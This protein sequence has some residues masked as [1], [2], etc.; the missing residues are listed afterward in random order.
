MTTQYYIE[1]IKGLFPDIGEQKILGDLDA[2]QKLF[3][4]ETGLLTAQ[5]ELS[6][7]S[8]N[9][10]YSLP[11]GFR[12]LLEVKMYDSNGEPIYFGSSDANITY[13]IQLDKFFIKSLDSTPISAFPSGINKAYL[14]YETLPTT[15]VSRSTALEIE[16]EFRDALK[17]YVLKNYFS[18][19]PVDT[20]AQGQVIKTRD[21]NAVRYHQGEYEKLRIKAKKYKNSKET[22]L[23]DTWNYQDAGR[24]RLPLRNNDTSY[25]STT[26]THVSALGE[27]YEKFA[28]FNVNTSDSGTLTPVLKVGYATMTATKTGSTIALASTADFGVDTYIVS[29]NADVTYVYNSSSSITITLPSFTDLSIQIFEYT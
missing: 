8:S 3:A 16:E 19:Y 13:E 11:T 28:L 26:I 23:G 25:S 6:S 21:W 4:T 7:I 10:A 17:H 15:L 20:L 22:T 14:I 5:G 24:V 27:I 2:A 29:N 18:Q 1:E 12:K 9:F